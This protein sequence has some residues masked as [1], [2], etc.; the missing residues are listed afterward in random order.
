M[1]V[2]CRLK[3]S[4]ELHDALHGFSYGRGTGTATLEANKAQQMDRIAHEPIFQ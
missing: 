3:Q 1:V 2:N 4:V